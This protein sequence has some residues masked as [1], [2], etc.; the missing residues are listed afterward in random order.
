M[1]KKLE[2]LSYC[3]ERGKINASSPF[4]PDMVAMEGA[5]E[6]TH[7]A[8]KEKVDIEDILNALILGMEEIGIKFRENKVF[9]PEVLMASK[10]MSAAMKYLTSYFKQGIVK[11]KGVLII[12]TVAGDLHDI[13]KNLVAIIIEGG[14]WKIIDL[15]TNVS[16]EKYLKAI[17]ENQGCFVGISALLTTTMINMEKTVVAIKNKFPSVKVMIGGAPVTKEFKDKIGADFY[18]YEPLSAMNYLNSCI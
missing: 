14:G 16:T 10:A 13:G 15:G 18:S 9:V 1:D 17:E 11:Q 12:G 4:P 8:I 7:T 6:L 5:E 2:Q 3:I